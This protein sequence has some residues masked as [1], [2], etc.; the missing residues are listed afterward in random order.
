MKVNFA[1]NVSD[2]STTVC[3]EFK[4]TGENVLS[5]QVSTFRT[6]VSLDVNMSA[7]QHYSAEEGSLYIC[8]LYLSIT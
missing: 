2:I 7:Q 4:R 5:R 8:L 3:Q 6:T 1:R